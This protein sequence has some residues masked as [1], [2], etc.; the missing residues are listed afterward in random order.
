VAE[1]LQRLADG[2]DGRLLAARVVITGTPPVADRLVR[3]REVWEAQLRA[4][5]PGAGAG[6]WIEKVELSLSQPP[7]PPEDVG[8]AIGAIEMALADARDN[9]QVRA[10]LALVFTDLRSK[11]GADLTELHELGLPD[12]G[13]KGVHHLLPE[14][15]G[16]LL[17]ALQGTDL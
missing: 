7:S 14:I 3:D 4:D 13:E 6:V 15:R 5:A 12:L 9:P 2:A 16:L 8:Q 10:E 17:A 11:L 1:Q